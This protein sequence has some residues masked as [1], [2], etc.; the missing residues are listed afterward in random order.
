MAPFLRRRKA[1]G[2]GP[3]S[4]CTDPAEMVDDLLADFALT[5]RRRG[6]NVA[7]YVQ[8]NNRGCAGR[9]QGCAPQIAYLDIASGA[10]VR[11]DRGDAVTY[12]RTAMQDA[13]DLLVISHFSACLGAT[14]SLNAHFGPGAA[15]GLPLLTSIA[16]QCIHKWHRYAREEGTML[17]PDP[18]SLSG[19]GR[20]PSTCIATS[21][22]A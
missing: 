18:A 13:A 19:H 15:P 22:S 1:L 4:W 3:A 14:D 5:L 12:L 11:V 17:S 7:G 10:T 16:G 6:F 9:G 21:P 20:A 2:S 8:H